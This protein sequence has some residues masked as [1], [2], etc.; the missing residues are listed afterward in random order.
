MPT[1]YMGRDCPF[2]ALGRKYEQEESEELCFRFGIELVAETT[3]KEMMMKK[4]HL[5]EKPDV[6]KEERPDSDKEE[7]V[8]SDERRTLV[9]I[10]THDLDTLEGPFTYEA[11]PPSSINFIPP[12]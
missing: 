11:L 3:K 2:D 8:D 5:E 4:K 9:S 1:V 6:N 12:G 10:G 7:R